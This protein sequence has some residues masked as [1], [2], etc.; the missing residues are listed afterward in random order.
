MVASNLPMRIVFLDRG[1][2]RADVVL[3]AMPFDYELVEHL[4]TRPGEV[5]E[6]C[7]QTNAN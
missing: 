1:T 4:Q 7:C 6:R 3:P 2:L 5:I